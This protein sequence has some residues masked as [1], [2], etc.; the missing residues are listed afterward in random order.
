V[1]VNPL[2]DT[3][4]HVTA[5]KTPGCFAYDTVKITVNQSPPINLGADKRFCLGDS[6]VFSAG[7][8]FQSYGWNS[9]QTTPQIVVK[10][11]GQYSV[12]GTTGEGCKSYDTVKVISVYH[13]L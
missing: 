11:V 4:Y 2:V 8:G 3:S 7:T 6:T 10:V 13:C 9:G 12:V 1:V 5:E